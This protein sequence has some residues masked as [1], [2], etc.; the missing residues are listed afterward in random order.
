M[1]QLGSTQSKIKCAVH[2]LE[3]MKEAMCTI[4]IDLVKQTNKQAKNHNQLNRTDT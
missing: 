2:I 3:D 1:K 4:G